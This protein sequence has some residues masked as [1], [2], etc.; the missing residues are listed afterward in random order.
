MSNYNILNFK[1]GGKI[2]TYLPIQLN[3]LHI[4]ISEMKCQAGIDEHYSSNH[5]TKTFISLCY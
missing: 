1:I 2:D 5:K 3:L 4:A